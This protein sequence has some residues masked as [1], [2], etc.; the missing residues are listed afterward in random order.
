M[1]A[2]GDESTVRLVAV[3]E[4]G[5]HDADDVD[6]DVEEGHEEAESLEEVAREEHA[7]RAR[8]GGVEHA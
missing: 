4:A 8:V 6:A 3:E 1:R 5:G 7:E 2:A